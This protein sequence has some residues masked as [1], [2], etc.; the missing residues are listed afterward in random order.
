MTTQQT[1]MRQVNIQWQWVGSE[2]HPDG[3]AVFYP[4]TDFEFKIRCANFEQAHH[5][6]KQLSKRETHVEAKT[7]QLIKTILVD[8]IASI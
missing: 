2:N 3:T 7:K 8:S 1:T 4:G 6:S 5:I